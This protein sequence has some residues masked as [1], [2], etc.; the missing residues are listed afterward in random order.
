[1]LKCD[2]RAAGPAIRLASTA[3]ERDER[4]NW[5]HWNY[6]QQP[7]AVFLP[8]GRHVLTIRILDPG[9]LNLD[10]IDFTHSP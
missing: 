4:R 2:E 9:N 8:A 7:D 1:L 6:H 10:R 3:D 5:H